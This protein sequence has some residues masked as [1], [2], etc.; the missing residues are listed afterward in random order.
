[1]LPA[2]IKTR[3]TYLLSN[4]LCTSTANL[5]QRAVTVYFPYLITLFYL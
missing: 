1:M 5:L 4:C 2:K 3:Q